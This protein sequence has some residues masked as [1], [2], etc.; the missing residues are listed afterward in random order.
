MKRVGSRSSMQQLYKGFKG[1]MVLVAQ[2][3][4]VSFGHLEKHKGC[5]NQR[6]GQVGLSRV[7]QLFV[8]LFYGCWAIT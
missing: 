5:N 3:S 1:V 6:I 4:T 7:Q 8:D 2:A